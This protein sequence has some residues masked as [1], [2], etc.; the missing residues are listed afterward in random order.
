MDM[1]NPH[2]FVVD[3]GVGIV[4]F[5]VDGVDPSVHPNLYVF[6]AEIGPVVA[7]TSLVE[8]SITVTAEAEG[9]VI[10]RVGSR[11]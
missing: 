7:R 1:D 10:H 5:L 11:A 3:F 4:A 6:G 8:V 2:V 9:C